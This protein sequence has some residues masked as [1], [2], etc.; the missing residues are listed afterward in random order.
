MSGGSVEQFMRAVPPGD[1]IVQFLRT[2]E[3]K[4][5]EADLHKR[6]REGDADVWVLR[7]QPSSSLSQRFG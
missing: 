7:V 1:R 2:Q 3:S 5:T 4:V 6:P